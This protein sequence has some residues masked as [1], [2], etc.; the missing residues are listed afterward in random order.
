MSDTTT[1]KIIGIDPKRYPDLSKNNYIDI[2]YKLSEKA[3]KQ[4]CVIFN[5][6]F[7]N[8]GNVRIDIDSS[9]FIDTWVRDMED[10]P[11]R[12]I[13]I[14]E[15]IELTNKLYQEKLIDDEK[16]KKDS[17]NQNKSEK[18]IRLDE[19]LDSLDFNWFLIH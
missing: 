16:A 2:S 1:I 3:P 6:I 14:K 7:K 4:W 18:S 8:D 19:I 11:W 9:Q 10:I 15:K 5:D 13:T 12:F 17:Y